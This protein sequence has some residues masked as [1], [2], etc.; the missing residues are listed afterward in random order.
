MILFFLLCF[1][2]KFKKF[3]PK[4]PDKYHLKNKSTQTFSLFAK[5]NKELFMINFILNRYIFTNFDRV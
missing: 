2:L 3:N 4:K 1:L 5:G